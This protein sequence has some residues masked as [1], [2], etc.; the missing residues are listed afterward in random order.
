MKPTN[1]TTHEDTLDH[2]E[3]ESKQ[4][5]DVNSSFLGHSDG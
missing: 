3:D 2:E 4:N 5:E 1:Q